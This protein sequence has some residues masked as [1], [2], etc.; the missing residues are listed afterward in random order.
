M[1][2]G[3]TY[4]GIVAHAGG[5]S[6]TPATEFE[7][8]YSVFL[9]LGTL[10]GVVVIGYTLYNALKYRDGGDREVEGSKKVVRPSLGEL[11]ESSGGGRKLFVSFGISAVIVVSLIVWTYSALLYVDDGPEEAMN[12]A[13]GNA[14]TLEVDVIGQQFAWIFV[15]PNG[16]RN[17]TLVVPEGRPVELNVTSED[18]MHNI[19]IPAFNAK[20]DAIPGQTTTAWFVPDETGTFK[21]N[22]YELCGSGHSVMTS[23]VVVKEP[24]EYEEWYEN[25]EE[26]GGNETGTNA[27]D[28]ADGMNE[29][30]DSG[31]N[32]TDSASLAP[33][34]ASDA[35]AAVPTPA[36]AVTAGG[37]TR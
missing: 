32:D 18:V 12:S 7:S 15:Y 27:S 1:S 21:A 31:G 14:T 4:H 5:I 17:T 23:D 35:S 26:S 8:I 34:A 30:D 29:S 36:R 19:G 22:C 9:V 24:E 3:V 6:R 25:R 33:P 37:G 2:I 20:T 28:D 11:P 16:H 13:E 10:V